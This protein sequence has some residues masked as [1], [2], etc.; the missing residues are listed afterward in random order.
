MSPQNT[1][2]PVMPSHVRHNRFWGGLRLIST[3]A[4]KA[5]GGAI[6]WCLFG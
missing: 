4:G 5:L 1:M 6:L 2:E 3:T